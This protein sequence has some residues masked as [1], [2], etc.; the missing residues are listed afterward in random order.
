[1]RF[2]TI[3]ESTPTPLELTEEQALT[4]W[5][6]GQKLVRDAPSPEGSDEE[7]RSAIPYPSRRPP[8]DGRWNVMVANAVGVLRVG[9]DLQIS[10][11]PK[12]PISHLMY[13]FRLASDL[14]RF[15]T[16]RALLDT[17]T[18]LWEL[19]ARWY[20]SATEQALRLEITRDY[21]PTVE[22][23]QAIRG[24]VD[25]PRLALDVYRGRLEFLCEFEDFSENTPLN[26]VLKAAAETVVGSAL[27]WPLRQRALRLVE[28]LEAA[29]PVQP[30]DLSIE[31][32][33]RT[34]HCTSAFALATHVLQSVGR[35]AA[36]GEAVGWSFLIP[37]PA[38]VEQGIRKLLRSA[39][40]GKWRV[41]KTAGRT[42]TTVT[43]NPDLLFGGGLATA[44]VKYKIPASDWG[45]NRSD[46][47]Q[48]ITFATAFRST[49]AAI[50]YFVPPDRQPPPS[51]PVGDVDLAVLTW[52]SDP[53]RKPDEAAEALVT[54]TM[55]WLKNPPT[56]AL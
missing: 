21:W 42:G 20:V 35:T 48:A 14:P 8:P 17:D 50:V 27:D 12:I 53:A 18:D 26:R 38:M 36:Q 44:D 5:R 11:R 23:T 40:K 49:R 37:T 46:L 6:L 10:V 39:L 56:P 2:E 13:L 45:R 28:L 16:D 54:Q 52:P 51:T 7:G 34:A 1:M 15:L 22:F 24:R 19:V 3:Q 55:D 31:L 47:N 43:F 32:D 25:A 41:G 30:G 4:L 9:N 33:R 29:S